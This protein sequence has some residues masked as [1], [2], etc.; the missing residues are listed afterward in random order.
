MGQEEAAAPEGGQEEGQQE[1]PEIEARARE[2]GWQPKDQFKGPEERWV[3][4]ETFIQRGEEIM[5]ILQANNRKLSNE[6]QGLRQ[7]SAQQAEA[8]RQANESIEE[9][10]TFNAEI[11]ASRAKTRRTELMAEIRKAREDEN[12]ELEDELTQELATLRAPPPVRKATGTAPA[13]TAAGDPAALNPE[14]KEWVE[15]NTWFGRDQMRTDLA[16]VIGRRLRSDPQYAGVTGK[17]FLQ[18]VAKQVEAT[19]GSGGVQRNG[20]AKVEGGA[21]GSSAGGGGSPAGKSYA[22]LPADAK[23][24]CERQGKRLVGEN[25]A[26]KTVEAWRKHYVSKYFEAE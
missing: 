9:L 22:D 3:D 23:E 6:L 16:T 21:R 18:E 5:P 8:L 26:F 2:M 15:E 1:R 13:G 4:A 14:W 17:A 11:A 10:K 12:V 19:L 7:L 24:A 25:R 20:Q